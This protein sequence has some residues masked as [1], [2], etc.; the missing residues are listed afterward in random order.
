MRGKRVC[1]RAGQRETL[2]AL[3][4]GGLTLVGTSACSCMCSVEVPEKRHQ[5]HL[6]RKQKPMGRVSHHTERAE[7]GLAFS[8]DCFPGSVDR[9][10]ILKITSSIIALKTDVG[11]RGNLLVTQVE[12]GVLT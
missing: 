4:C 7:M 2:Q 9:A 1:L 6:G 12:R 5:S 11:S 8:E 3:L 10:E